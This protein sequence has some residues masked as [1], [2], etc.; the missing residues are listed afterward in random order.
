MEMQDSVYILHHYH[1]HSSNFP[2]GHI[3]NFLCFYHV[4]TGEMIIMCMC[5]TPLPQWVSM[6]EMELCCCIFIHDNYFNSFTK[7]QAFKFDR[8]MGGCKPTCL[9]DCLHQSTIKKY[10]IIDFNLESLKFRQTI[11]QKE[12]NR[13]KEPDW[14]FPTR[15]KNCSPWQICR[16]N[17]GSGYR[18]H[19]GYPDTHFIFISFNAFMLLLFIVSAINHCLFYAFEYVLVVRNK[20]SQIDR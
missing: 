8:R 15:Q 5:K 19:S 4:E 18:T 11:E 10:K 12:L 17:C 9:V 7:K 2:V 6:Q 16:I 20:V 3:S 13:Q 1:T 14:K